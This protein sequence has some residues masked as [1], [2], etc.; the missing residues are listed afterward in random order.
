MVRTATSGRT[1]EQPDSGR[2][3]LLGFRIA[4]RLAELGPTTAVV[5]A[6]VGALFG[7]FVMLARA[8][9]DIVFSLILL[10]LFY[11]GVG[12][13]LLFAAV[14]W[15]V[16]ELDATT[17]GRGTFGKRIFKLRVSRL[18]GHPPGSGRSLLRIGVMAIGHM[19]SM[20]AAIATEIPAFSI[21][22]GSA[23]LIVALAG[24]PGVSIHDYVA[25]TRVVPAS[26]VVR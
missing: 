11:L 21:A 10:G 13:L 6:V 25:G 24:P 17:S 20:A 23:D 14:C 16:Y 4:A 9:D 19:G 22:Y 15:C 26:S 1:G 5:G 8:G 7:A 2:W 18:D 12:A 3:P